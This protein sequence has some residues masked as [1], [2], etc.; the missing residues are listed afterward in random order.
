MMVGTPAWLPQL[1]LLS[2]AL[3]VGDTADFTEEWPW[4]NVN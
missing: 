3:P 2:L 1:I 4:V